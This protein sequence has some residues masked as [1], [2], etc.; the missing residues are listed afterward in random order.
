MGWA[1]NR[2]TGVSVL[3]LAGSLCVLAGSATAQERG[4]PAQPPA[5]TEAPTPVNAATQTTDDTGLA[6]IVVTAEKRPSTAQRTAVALDVFDAETLQ[7]NG[8]GNIAQLANFSPSI[9]IG[10]SAGASIVTIRGV[11]SRD[12]TEIGDP[13]VAISI[14]GVYLQRPT[15]M[16]AS[17]YDLDRVEA[18]RGPQGTL[19]G[20]NATGGAINI[21]TKKPTNRTEGYVSVDAGN[22]KTIN[23]DGAVNT[24]LTDTLATR[25]SFV[26]RY[27]QGY[28]DNGAGGRG[29][30]NNAKGGRLQFLWKP[31]DRLSVLVGGSYLKQGGTGSVYNN[32][33]TGPAGL[34]AVRP[35]EKARGATHFGLNYAGYFD[36]EIATANVQIDYDLSFATATYIGGY[37]RTNYN[38]SWDNDGGTRQGYIYTRD[39]V[40]K[41]QS[42]E[43]RLASN[44]PFG[45]RWQIGAF[46]FN[47]DLDLHNRF[48]LTNASNVNVN[49]REYF[50]DVD[51]KSYA[52]FG[53]ASYDLSERLK[54]T[55]G[56]RYSNDEKSRFGPQYVGALTQNVN[57]GTAVR[58]FS[59]ENSSS[60]SDKFTYHAGLDFQATPRNLLYAKFD[61]GYKAGGFNNF[62]LGQ[63]EPE[64]LTA[65]EVGS[66]NRFLN[67]ALQV[68][69]GAY[70][71][72]Y[73]DQ[74]VSQ[75]VAAQASTQIVNAGESEIY[76]AEAEVTWKIAK[77]DQLDVSA[78]YLHGEF[79]D[80]AVGNGTSNL[81]LDGNRTV[82]SPRWSVTGG[83]QHDFH[84]LGGVLTPRVQSQYRSS[85]FL[86]IYNRANDRQD[87]FSRTDASL[88]YAPD[89]SS[90]S[91]QAYVRN[92]ENTVVIS[93][94]EQSALYAGVRY[95]YDA[96]RTYGARLLFNF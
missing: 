13:A 45:F 47:E 76:G 96:P 26:S 28:R 23:V 63:Y 22:Y 71:Y 9:S 37:N 6:E 85:S 34:A 91:I 75:F 69:I 52:F 82:Q 20:R 46:Y 14:D 30:D 81:V 77:D 68:N 49:L 3:A 60:K 36:T 65:Y 16:N 83:Y 90:L 50:F 57:G 31:A 73:S 2:V 40:S 39:E 59:I 33:A 27:N 61:T 48:D 25:L 51:T 79:T 38:H 80:L 92:I 95:Q 19:Y 44:N 87:G 93:N 86:T 11:S 32:V 58:A 64:T 78:S 7:K 55:G 15:G 35:P 72:Q 5:A 17:F 1:G 42:H 94:A 21:I 67:N 4:A 54:V 12:T 18:L 43:L 89:G 84:L 24:P 74:Q 70:Y 29:D 66:K 62:D 41:D 88:T 8:V 56:V 10:Q 53:Q